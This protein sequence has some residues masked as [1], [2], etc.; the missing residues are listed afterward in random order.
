MINIKF[1]EIYNY[2]KIVSISANTVETLSSKGYRKLT[3]CEFSWN[4]VQVGCYF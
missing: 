1:M 4:I 3:M 2:N